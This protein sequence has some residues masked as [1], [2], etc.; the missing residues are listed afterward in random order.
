MT[1][2]EKNLVLYLLE[3]LACQSSEIIQY[4]MPDI[5]TQRN[6]EITRKELKLDE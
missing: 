1:K 6:I 2:K 5:L 4:G 3:L